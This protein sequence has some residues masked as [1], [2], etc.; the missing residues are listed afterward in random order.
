MSEKE[1]RRL[2][3]QDNRLVAASYQVTLDEKRLLLSAISELD[4]TSKD[5]MKGSVSITINALEWAET[6]QIH[7]GNAY[8]QLRGAMDTLADRWVRVYGDSRKGKDMRWIHAKEWDEGKGRCTITFA[9]DILKE[10]T[11]LFD[12]FTQY[13]LLSVSGLKSIYSVRFYELCVQFKSTGWRY[14]E[15]DE[16]RH[17]FKLEKRYSQFK[18]LRRNVID[19]AIDELNQKSDLDVS[20]EP[21]KRG[22][23]I[24]AIKLKVKLKQQFDL[25]NGPTK[26]LS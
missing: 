25:F 11:S 17:M 21:V 20:W 19:K 3:V 15:I 23:T 14:L 6:Y 2:V 1:Q 26:S 13:E 4:P 8:K 12:H 24:H 22:R 16:L 10:L 5:W 18:E 7:P 9:D